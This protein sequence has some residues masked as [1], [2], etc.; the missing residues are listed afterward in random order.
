M[1]LQFKHNVLFEK[2]VQLK[3]DH[4]PVFDY[5]NYDFKGKT[6]R[7]FNYNLAN[8]PSFKLDAALEC[9]GITF[10]INSDGDFVKLVSLP[11]QKFF[12][13][14]ENPFT[15]GLEDD[16]IM[17]A[18]DKQ[19]GSLISTFLHEGEVYLKSKGAFA[20]QQA[21]DANNLLDT[22]PELKAAL[23]KYELLGFTVNLEYTAPD[24][25]IVLQYQKPNLAILN[26]RNRNTGEYLNFDDISAPQEH[27]VDFATQYHGMTLRE[28]AQIVFALKG[29]E[30]FVVLT[31][32]GKWIKFKT[33]WY[34][35]RHNT[36]SKFSPFTRKGKKEIIMS[37]FNETTDDVRQLFNGN[38]FALDVL[39]RAE[40][41]VVDYMQEIEKDIDAFFEEYGHLE[42][43]YFFEKVNKLHSDDNVKFSCI[44]LS[45]QKR[46]NVK[47]QLIK[48]AHSSKIDKFNIL[49]DDLKE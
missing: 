5:K 45:R 23:L 26:V 24:N 22:L 21:V 46:V 18:M 14:Q 48:A 28:F 42:G 13:Y 27:I 44:L 34:V 3:K 8:Y 33:D 49:F 9:R 15:E 4:H 30:G 39:S 12:N 36:V 17:I 25:Q 6:Y 7:I 47:E 35:Q 38:K 2:L 31:E 16:K 10:E 19:D 11:M 20:S 29:I 37:V 1:L 43:K 40:Q 41:F 32:S